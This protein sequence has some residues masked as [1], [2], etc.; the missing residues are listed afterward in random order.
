MR[1]IGFVL[2]LAGAAIASQA[3]AAEPRMARWQAEAAR[4]T[5]VRDDWGIA[6]VRGRTD[7]ESSVEGTR[8]AQGDAD[9]AREG[10]A[11]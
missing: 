6:H 2:A 11:K 10:G 8:A 9:T 3:F 1:A 5:I 7:A 4:V